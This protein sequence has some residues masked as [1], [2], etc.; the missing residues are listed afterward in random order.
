MSGELGVDISV[1]RVNE[2]IHLFSASHKRDMRAEKRTSMSSVLFDLPRRSS[3]GWQCLH[4]NLGP[5]LRELAA[6]MPP[7]EIGRRMG[8][9]GCRPYALQPFI[10]VCS[11]LAHRQQRMLDLG[12]RPGD[13]FPEERPEELAFLMDFWA[14]LQGGYRT[15]EVL[16]PAQADDSL[17]IL[18]PADIDALTAMATAPDPDFYG[19]VRRLA[20]TL[21]LYGFML[22]GEQRDGI[23]GH[24][25]YDL[26]D[27]TVLF[28]REFND[29]RNDFL[30][31]AATE[32]RVPIGNVVL[33]YVAR[34]VEVICDMFGS[35][36][37]EP[38]E[39]G[40]RL[41]GLALLTN[42]SGKL[43][44]IDAGEIEAIQKAAADAQEELFMRAVEWDDA[45][46][47][48][49]GAPLF[50]NHVKPFFE[51]AGMANADEL[52]NR[53]LEACEETARA[54]TERL[55]GAEVPSV[56]QHF[57]A[58]DD[59]FYWPLVV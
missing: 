38:H 1:E 32:V 58:G 23:F 39:L 22:H 27:G 3:L 46:K 11:H 48:A 49:Y 53:L 52:G 43:R 34:D 31:W 19:A 4:D 56:W 17:P 13:P 37:F 7:E 41:L 45:Y 55:L 59:D 5:Y 50:A 15:D 57:A 10:L 28:C 24:G 51:L 33:A 44:A 25:P 54:N 40:D 2:L 20:A 12:L 35:S 18:E 16:L 9:V 36:R 21:E 8:T 42:D 29:L 14:R 6:A 30:P 26:G 47:I